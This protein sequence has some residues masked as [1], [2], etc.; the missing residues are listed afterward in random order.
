[1]SSF[2][3]GIHYNQDGCLIMLFRSPYQ[4]VK[5]NYINDVSIGELEAT[6]LLLFRTVYQVVDNDNE[7]LLSLVY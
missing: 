4:V 3:E 7:V 2:D 5:N 1:M 6:S